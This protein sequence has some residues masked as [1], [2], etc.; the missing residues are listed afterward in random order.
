MKKC[1]KCGIEKSLTEFHKD[2]NKKDGRYTIC[3]L[4]RI[5]KSSEYYNKNKK[6]ISEKSV[7][8]RARP[9]VKQR[10]RKYDSNRRKQPE[11][12]A[13]EKISYSKYKQKMLEV[14]VACIYKIT[15]TINNRSYIGETFQ[16]E[17]R[18]NHHFYSL[19]NGTHRNHKL[20]QDFDEYG[21]EAFEWS[22]IK[23]LPKDR[24]T[25]LLEEAREIE[26]RV[27]K[28]EDLYNRASKNVK[29]KTLDKH[30][31]HVILQTSEER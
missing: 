22:I 15:N 11:V 4:C 3:K 30:A 16:S 23:T 9:D 14:S 27:H 31:Q 10:K 19:R 21:E 12:I 1:S 7:A 20:Q 28:G 17:L 18:H 13:R 25:L 24:D 26:R 6:Q 29:R 8:Y 5:S 2:K